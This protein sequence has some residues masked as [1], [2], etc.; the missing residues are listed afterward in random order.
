[1][2]ALI[3]VG[4]VILVNQLEGNLLQPLIMGKSLS[5]HPLAI[6]L[7]LTA[8][9]VLGGVIGAVLAVPITSVL[10]TAVKSWND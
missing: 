4:I 5:L 2:V 1:V 8:G 3:V 6:L 7:A 9:T 10:W